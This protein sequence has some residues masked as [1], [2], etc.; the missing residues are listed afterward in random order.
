[1]EKY[2]SEKHS[3]K[4][5]IINSNEFDDIEF[6]PK[7]ITLEKTS[8]LF[9][10]NVKK[11]YANFQLWFN[12][13][14]YIYE[15]FNETY[16]YPFFMINTK[17]L[18]ELVNRQGKTIPKFNNVY[19]YINLTYVNNT[20]NKYCFL[21][22]KKDVLVVSFTSNPDR[23]K[24]IYSAFNYPN[25][26][27]IDH[28]LPKD[29]NKIKKNYDNM[30]LFNFTG[31]LP[32][33]DNKEIPSNK[34]IYSSLQIIFEHLNKG[35]SCMFYGVT[36]FENISITAL[37]I[38]SSYFENVY[39]HRPELYIYSWGCW[40][41]CENYK[42]NGSKMA[43]KIKDILPKLTKDTN[44]LFDIEN[45]NYTNI[46]SF[47]YEMISKL[48]KYLKPIEFRSKEYIGKLINFYYN[49]EGTMVITEYY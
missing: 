40:V 3:I 22:S 25:K 21:K 26:I 1:M 41:I 28:F 16:H 20:F 48:D 9:Y 38:L 6:T 37:L 39:L 5:N 8:K 44:Y 2:L 27:K 30:F 29:T 15:T 10:N 49:L 14:K 11:I 45:Y 12:P 34:N 43:E 42:G 7:T 24:F 47:N 32:S 23:E 33:N 46:L 35:G 18:D 17:I 4:L 19:H 31:R 36:F 13:I